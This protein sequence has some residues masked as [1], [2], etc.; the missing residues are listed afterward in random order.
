MTGTMSDLRPRLKDRAIHDQRTGAMTD[1]TAQDKLTCAVREVG[2]RQRVY[3]NRVDTG[4]MTQK[5]ADREIAMM[6]A[7][8]EDYQKLVESER[9]L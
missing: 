9:L 6:R 8:A 1:F 3:P 4:R 2:W 7:I 5:Q